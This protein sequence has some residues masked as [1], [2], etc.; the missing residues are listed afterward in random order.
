MVS[1][2]TEQEAKAYILGF[3]DQIRIN[4]PVSLIE[5]IKNMAESVLTLYK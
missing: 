4:H 1:F 2:D 3:G 5:S